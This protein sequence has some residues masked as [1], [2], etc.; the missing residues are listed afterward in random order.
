MVLNNA[1]ELEADPKIVEENRIQ[2]SPRCEYDLEVLQGISKKEGIILDVNSMYL[3]ELEESKKELD[4][5][6][7]VLN[8]ADISHD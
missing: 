1:I 4:T 5:F 7:S 2:I 8:T 3:L 6:C